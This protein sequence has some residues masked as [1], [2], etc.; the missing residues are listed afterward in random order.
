MMLPFHPTP[1]VV[2]HSVGCLFVAVGVVGMLHTLMMWRRNKW[3]YA[4]HRAHLDAVRAYFLHHM[5]LPI[6]ELD[7]Y[8]ESIEPYD[9]MLSHWWRGR[10]LE[11]FVTDSER[12][13]RLYE[14]GP[15]Q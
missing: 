3:V 11:R 9:T 4:I 2:V 6:D 10:R 8:Y 12:F 5:E 7:R 15:L 1:S 13:R 14:H